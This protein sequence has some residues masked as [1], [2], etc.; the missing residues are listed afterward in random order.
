MRP[1]FILSVFFLDF[2]RELESEGWHV[3]TDIE[4]LS[5]SNP[6]LESLGQTKE[7]R[8]AAALSQLQ[9]LYP[10]P[11]SSDSE[12]PN[13]TNGLSNGNG[14][15][16]EKKALILKNSHIGGHKFAGNVIVS[17]PSPCLSASFRRMNPLTK[18][19]FTLIYL[20]CHIDLLPPR[21][22]HLVR[23]SISPRSLL[24]RQKH[25]HPR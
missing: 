17:L 14:K 21:L 24:H 3:D 5:S 10:P 23:P 9:Q 1:D 22:K 2:T 12:S 19:H 7:E 11:S 8:E 15:P 18:F 6:N 16:Q 20:L 25:N 13:S 4:D